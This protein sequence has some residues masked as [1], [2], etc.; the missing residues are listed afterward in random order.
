MK[1]GPVVVKA[2]V[3]RA[4]CGNPRTTRSKPPLGRCGVAAPCDERQHRG[5]RRSRLISARRRGRREGALLLC[6]VT[7]GRARSRDGGGSLIFPRPWSG[8]RTA[9]AL[10]QRRSATAGDPGAEVSLVVRAHVR[11]PRSSE[12]LNRL[13]HTPLDDSV[14]V[15]PVN[16]TRSILR[17]AATYCAITGGA[18]TQS[19]SLRH[20]PDATSRNSG[21]QKHRNRTAHW[22]S[23]SD[24][25]LRS[26]IE[27]AECSAACNRRRSFPV[28]TA[29][30]SHSS[31]VTAVVPAITR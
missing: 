14:S 31:A 7:D 26:H 21:A 19:A 5:R 1:A 30:C 15:L 22:I 23:R 16:P 8:C 6:R 18:P 2:R 24:R 29:R 4:Y 10:G 28:R 20:H 25:P 11:S 12:R 9:K 3:G 13:V 27:L 17:K